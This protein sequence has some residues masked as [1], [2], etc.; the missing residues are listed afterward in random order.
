MKLTSI[1]P[2][3]LTQCADLFVTVFNN[4]PWNEHWQPSAVLAR[5]TDI[6][7]TP[8]FHGIAAFN[9]TVIVG[10]ALGYIEQWDQ[11]RVFYLKEMC[12]KTDLQRQGIGAKLIEYLERDLKQR[13]ISKIYLL[14]A[15]DSLAE[16]FY[17]KAGFYVSAKM[18]MM[19]KYLSNA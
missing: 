14:T 8:G 9:E 1:K 10:F 15:R 2:E 11:Q 6:F 12:V 4:E 5:L 7:H 19:A 17:R 13:S 18:I 3:D 16:A